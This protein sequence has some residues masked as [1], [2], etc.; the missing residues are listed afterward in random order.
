MTTKRE[1]INKPSKFDYNILKLIYVMPI[2]FVDKYGVLFIISAIAIT[3]LRFGDWEEYPLT[4]KRDI[5]DK[6][7]LM[8]GLAII[9]LFSYLGYTNKLDNGFYIFGKLHVPSYVILFHYIFPVL[10]YL[11]KDKETLNSF[12]KVSKSI[13]KHTLFICL[14][15]IVTNIF[16]V[17]IYPVEQ[18]RDVLI[19]NTFQFI[20]TAGLAEE[21]FYR[22]FVYNQMK[23]IIS[24]KAAI[25]VSAILFAVLHF[26][27]MGPI[28]TSFNLGSL[29]NLFAIFM[30]GV[31]CALIYEKAKSLI[32]VIVFHALV[33]GAL[34]GIFQIIKL[35]M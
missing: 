29:N 16:I 3:N 15:I 19:Q 4:K 2:I 9:A 1:I 35:S 34:R 14:P 13:L 33:D 7:I 31:A 25:F 30:L 21:M 28:I 17:L 11:L 8:V 18:P 26:N 23:K 20:F 27:V 22:G 10:F 32:P 24:V 12:F 6:V 5:L